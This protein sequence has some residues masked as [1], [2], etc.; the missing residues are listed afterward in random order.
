MK[1][2][3]LAAKVLANSAIEIIS[4]PSIIDLA[5]AEHISRVG[6]DFIYNPLL[7][8]RKPPLAYRKIN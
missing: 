5:K 7:G 4:N 1:G 8:D 2:T 3:E 6:E